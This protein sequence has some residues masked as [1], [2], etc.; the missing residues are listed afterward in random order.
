[1]PTAIDFRNFAEACTRL[2]QSADT[3][4]NKKTLKT[5]ATRWTGLAAQA[6]RIRQLVREA[7]AVFESS[8]AETEKPRLRPTRAKVESGS[9]KRR[10]VD[11][12]GADQSAGR[13]LNASSA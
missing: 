9:V 6:E 13:A 11:I 10:L 4:A 8:G 5:M 2:A 1:M 7:D 12:D 3:E